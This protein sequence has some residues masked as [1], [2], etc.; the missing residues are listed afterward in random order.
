MGEMTSTQAPV[1]M[2]RVAGFTKESASAVVD[3]QHARECRGFEQNSQAAPV[4]VV[5]VYKDVVAF[6]QKQVRRISE[7]L[8]A[9]EH[10]E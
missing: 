8:E 4:G 7:L 10:G 6:V 1:V 3:G 9:K 5:F 2:S